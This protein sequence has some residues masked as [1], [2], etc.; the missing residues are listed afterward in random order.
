LT[1][2]LRKKKPSGGASWKETYEVHQRFIAIPDEAWDANVVAVKSAVDTGK[3]TAI[4]RRF[5]SGPLLLIGHRRS[6]GREQAHK[7]ACVYYEDLKDWTNLP[8]R[9]AICL[10]SIPKL[11]SGL[12]DWSRGKPIP[13]QYPVVIDE[14]DQVLPH[15]HG[16]TLRGKHLIGRVWECLSTILTD[17]ASQVVVLDAH[18]SDTTMAHLERLM[19]PERPTIAWVRNTWK[20]SDSE[21]TRRKI[22]MYAH[23]S[24]LRD[25]LLERVKADSSYRP[26]ITCDT[27]ADAS[28]VHERLMDLDGDHG[29]LATA[30]TAREAKVRA[31]LTSPNDPKVG[32]VSYRWVCASPTIGSGISID[33]PVGNGAFTEV[34]LFAQGGRHT[35]MDLVQQVGRPRRLSEGTVRAAIS[36][37]SL[38]RPETLAAL[39]RDARTVARFATTFA[40]RLVGKPDGSRAW[41]PRDARMVDCGL[42]A[43]LRLNI[44]G[45][46]LRTRWTRYWEAQGCEVT[47]ARPCG[48][49]TRAAITK[50]TRAIKR[51]LEARENVAV[52]GVEALCVERA[53]EVSRTEARTRDEERAASSTSSLLAARSSASSASMLAYV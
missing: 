33:A 16:S 34:I 21:E 22:V 23:P 29:I 47:E 18:L 53:R 43:E 38:G 32:L 15:G 35:W 7:H 14:A 17:N 39:R 5:S 10:D 40:G 13:C 20:A 25:H 30:D 1:C 24:D 31:A 11:M 26:Y 6:L 52:A 45:S 48:P 9:L 4:Q 19:A 42:L 27:K 49:I 8:D 41:Q 37:Y 50:T 44:H 36:D 2:P 46:H 3:S 12:L 51:R 28:E